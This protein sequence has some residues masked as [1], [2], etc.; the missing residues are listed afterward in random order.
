MGYYT[1]YLNSALNFEGLTLER[2]KQLKAI[3]EFR[4]GRDILV[5]AV[6]FNKPIPLVSI[7]YS[8]LLPIRDQI[9]NLGGKKLDLILETPGGSGETAEDIVR[10]LRDKYEEIAVIIPGHAKSAGTIMAMSADEILM[11]P[12]ISA[13]GPIDAQLFWQGKIFS[14]DAFLEGLDKIKKEVIDTGTLNKTYIPIL[15]GI[16]PGEIQNAVNALNFAKTLVTNWLAQYKFKTW[17]IHSKLGSPVTQEEKVKRAEEIANKLCDHKHWL[18]HGRSIKL[19]DLGEMKLKITDYSQNQKLAEAINRY[20][21]LMQ[22]SFA[23]PLYKLFETPETQINRFLAPLMQAQPQSLNPTPANANVA[24]IDL[25]CNNCKTK[26]KIQMNLDKSA[27]LQPG[28]TAFPGNNIF[29]CG[30]CGV[31]HNLAK[32]REQIEGQTKKKIVF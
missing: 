19:K 18:T 21:T 11:D 1:E 3:S 2:K 7:N 12:S 14:A 26:Y 31:E 5:F 6:D 23:S 17:N 29:K 32:I 9:S 15:Q 8:D 25:M 16:S 24:T 13:L 28:A 20:Y 4:G 27:P 22:M 10:L 30:N